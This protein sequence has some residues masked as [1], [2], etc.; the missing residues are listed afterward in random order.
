MPG[1]EKE[2]QLLRQKVDLL[3][4]G[5]QVLYMKL[6]QQTRMLERLGQMQGHNNQHADTPIDFPPDSNVVRLSER[7]L[8]RVRKNYQQDDELDPLLDP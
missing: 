6:E 3:I 8:D 1:R 2:L 4:D 5:Y 7:F